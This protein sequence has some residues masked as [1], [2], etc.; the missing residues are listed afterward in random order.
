MTQIAGSHTIINAAPQEAST[1]VRSLALF[2]EL[3]DR[4]IAQ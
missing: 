1:S 3:I 2:P 4:R